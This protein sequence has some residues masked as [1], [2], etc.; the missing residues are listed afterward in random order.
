MPD[1]LMRHRPTHGAVQRITLAKKGWFLLALCSVRK[2][3]TLAELQ[4]Q[5]KKTCAKRGKSQHHRKVLLVHTSNS[6]PGYLNI[7]IIAHPDYSRR[8][9]NSSVMLPVPYYIVYS[10][11]YGLFYHGIYCGSGLAA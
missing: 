6:A 11:Y 2:W 3:K 5:V 7:T 10:L 4:T 9:I 8:W 1:L